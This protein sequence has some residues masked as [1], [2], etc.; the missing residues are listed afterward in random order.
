LRSNNDSILYRHGRVTADEQV[1]Q[2]Q[3]GEIAPS[4]SRLGNTFLV[5]R[6][7]VEWSRPRTL[8]EHAEPVYV[9]KIVEALSSDGYYEV[10]IVRSIPFESV[11]GAVH[12]SL[13]L[14]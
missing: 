11:R 2:E 7:V 12:W 5:R 6:I 9:H 3:F 1:L 13:N 14:R 4:V 8:N 10:F